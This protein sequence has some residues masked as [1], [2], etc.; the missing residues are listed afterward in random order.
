M[1]VCVIMSACLCECKSCS[2]EACIN[3]VNSLL[4]FLHAFLD[5]M[6]NANGGGLLY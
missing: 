1:C 4:S 3:Q 2:L 6:N 5:I